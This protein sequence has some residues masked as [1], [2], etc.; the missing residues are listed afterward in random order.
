M[1]GT[2]APHWIG[3]IAPDS[4]ALWRATSSNRYAIQA[5][6]IVV[7]NRSKRDIY[8]RTENLAAKHRRSGKAFAMRSI[9][10]IRRNGGSWCASRRRRRKTGVAPAP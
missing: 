3:M 8:V 5:V 10:N 4:S 9:R 2:G 1:E 6:K 7:K